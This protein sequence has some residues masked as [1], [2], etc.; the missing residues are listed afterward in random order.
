MRIGIDMLAVQSPE[1][2]HRGIGRYSAGL[3]SAMLR[4]HQNHDFILYVHAD[5]PDAR[6]P[7]STRA[8]LQTIRPRWDAGET[9]IACMDRVARENPDQLDVLLVL[10]PF[11]NWAS[12]AP[13]AQPRSGLRI[14]SV[15]HDVAPFLADGPPHADP[16]RMRHYRALEE[17]GRYDRL[18]T[19]SESTRR[20][21]LNL[22]RLP[23][24][25]VAT[26][27][28]ASD[29]RTF[30]PDRARAIPNSELAELQAL[31]IN[32]PFLFHIGSLNGRKNTW[33]LID[34]FA[35]LPEPIWRRF[36]LVLTLDG[37]EWDRGHVL[38][39][40]RRVGLG[41]ALVV[42]GHVSDQMLA[43]LYQRCEAFVSP[44]L[45]EG[46]ALALIEAIHCGA[47][48]IAGNNSAQL[49][50]VGDSGLFVEVQDVSDIA[51]KILR[52]LEEPGLADSL[53][54]RVGERA[55]HFSW[56]RT[57][58]AALEA[59]AAPT[60]RRTTRRIRFDRGHARKPT[61]AFFS[62]LPPRK[63]GI[64]DYSAFLLQEL[65]K[66][67]RIELFHDPGYIPEP[68]LGSDEFLAC[69]ARVF[70]RLA[71]AKNYHAIVYQMGNS[72]YHNFMYTIM[73]RHPG[74]VTLHDFCLVNFYMGY[75]R[76]KRRGAD[77][78][79]EELER[80]HPAGRKEIATTS[81]TWSNDW[82]AIARDCVR[83]GWHMN[84]EI[85]D[86]SALTVVHSPWCAREVDRWSPQ[87]SDRVVVIPHGIH[88][89]R[90][91][92]RR[93]AEIRE[94][95]GIPQ[96]ALVFGSFGFIHPD[97]LQC[98][99]LVAF[100]PIAARDPSAVF[101]FVGED[102]DGGALRRQAA[103]LGLRDRVRFLGRQ[104]ASAFAELMLVTDLGVNLR[105]PPTN[106]ETSG[107]LLS[108]LASGVPTIATEV[109][110]FSDYPASVV[111]KVRWEIDGQAGLNH[112]MDWLASDPEARRTLGEA[113]MAYV[114]ELHEWSRV[115]KLY[116]DAIERCHEATASEAARPLHT[117]V[118]VSA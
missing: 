77:F 117:R 17:L 110:T 41:D 69:D 74:V 68:A 115:A 32:R 4:W 85:L 40:A 51:A 6:L 8:S 76:E 97:K 10:S 65:K 28:A 80:W 1:H 27:G 9:I 98:E 5:L 7:C 13:P 92:D 86:R 87:Y 79:R 29:G 118:R 81:A 56:Q 63:S 75:G 23:T 20:D 2:G 24:Q 107:A 61:I 91:S 96:K 36:Q 109:A 49:E 108:L 116:V 14:A 37:S 73:T 102:A 54:A 70:D 26:I 67:Y 95:F 45:H 18:L 43:V 72:R 84:R 88:L 114:D 101:L 48:I 71:A 16:V 42:T 99:A 52:V 64:S 46:C 11:E 21:L 82:E 53:R 111:L 89:R 15:V 33:A 103:A 58:D 47:P 38:D 50:T 35:S 25:Q 44:A 59:L 100:Q 62:P 90:A 66:T 83:H 113:A 112:A 34:A 3:V 105:M 19:A 106:G 78:V 104:P 30:V 31:G 93:R 60:V 57:A 55:S 39:H 12:Y 94:R 22:L